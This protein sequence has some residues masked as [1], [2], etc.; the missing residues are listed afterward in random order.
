VPSTYQSLYRKYRPVTFSEIIGQRHV[1]Q[2]LANAVATG[3]VAHAY[4]FCGPR[5]TGKTTTARA[6]AMA[7]NCD[8]G[9]SAEPCRTCDS[10]VEIRR[11]SCLDVIEF[12]AASH[13]G[14]R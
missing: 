5:G 6:L 11:G 14:V 2:T 12:D 13:R 8:Q 3:R 1:T 7:L 9:P 10:C 4:L